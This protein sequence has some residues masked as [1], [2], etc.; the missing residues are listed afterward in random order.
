MLFPI[1][2]LADSVLLLDHD[3]LPLDHLSY[4]CGVFSQVHTVE[5]LHR[6]YEGTVEVVHRHIE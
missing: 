6:G 3:L 4:H 2:S 5:E 1:A